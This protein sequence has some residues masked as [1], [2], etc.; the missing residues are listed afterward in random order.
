MRTIHPATRDTPAGTLPTERIRIPVHTHRQ[1][2]TVLG[3]SSTISASTVSA[4]SISARR[5]AAT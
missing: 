3:H 1:R 2:Q 5:A 4:S